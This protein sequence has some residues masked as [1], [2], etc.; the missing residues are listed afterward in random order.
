MKIA[1]LGGTFDP[2]H[3]GHIRLGQYFAEK[4]ELDKVLIIPTRT[5]P[6]KQKKVTPAEHRLE[7]CRIAAEYAG[8]KFEV[9]DIELRRD[10][11]S[12]S[13][14]TLQSLHEMYPGYELY[15][16]TGA[17]M[18]VTL[19]KWHR[20]EELRELATF[21]TV[22]RDDITGEQLR[23][24]AAQ[25]T[26]CRLIVSE[27]AVMQVSSTAIRAAAANGGEFDHLVPPGVAEYIRING[28]YRSQE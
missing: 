10:G 23:E 14:Y 19:D 5:P 26:G 27:E 15:M 16:L 11:L 9:S 4:L 17:D 7:M 21:C 8:D 22:A 6:H 25:L 1:M 13:F 18:F 28:L 3:L 20:Y 12:Y 24:K 2:I